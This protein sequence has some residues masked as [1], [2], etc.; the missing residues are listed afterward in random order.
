MRKRSHQGWLSVGREWLGALARLPWWVSAGLS[1]GAMVFGWVVLRFVHLPGA[2]AGGAIGALDEVL[3]SPALSKLWGLLALVFLFT[4]A[5]SLR[6]Q[7]ERNALLDGQR[8][9][10][11]IKA[12]SWQAFEQ[13]VG[14][15]YQRLGYHV[16][17]T[18]QGGADGGIDLLL[19][20]D[21]Q[22][23]LVQCKKWNSGNVGAPVVREMFGLM[24]H[25]QA[26]GV[27]IICAGRFSKDAVTFAQGKD[28]ELVDGEAL[29]NLIGDIQRGEVAAA[30]L[31]CPDCKGPMVKRF[32]RDRGRMFYGCQKYPKCDGTRSMM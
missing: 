14:N 20:K 30:D 17:E 10:A 32:S 22:I 13:L 25:H 2:Q 5:R 8:S 24:Q 19:K 1:A 3:H 15:A 26:S 27:K 11:T 4:G 9:L 23:V 16:T 18:G 12:L 21:G 7:G 29:M 28:I 6:R 31:A